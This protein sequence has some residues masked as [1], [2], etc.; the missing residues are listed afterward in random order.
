MSAADGE[1]SKLSRNG[2]SSEERPPRLVQRDV[3]D[4]IERTESYNTSSYVSGNAVVLRPNAGQSG[5]AGLWEK[6]I[7][8]PAINYAI[9]LFLT[10][11]LLLFALGAAFAIFLP[12]EPMLGDDLLRDV[13]PYFWGPGFFLLAPWQRWDTNW[14]LHIAQ[15]GYQA[16]DGTTNF[17]PLY[18]L[19]V[20]TVGRLLL[21]QYMLAALLVSAV[22]YLVAMVYLYRLTERFFNAQLAKRTLV[23]LVCFPTAFFLLS[24][25]TESLYLALAV[26]SFYYAEERRWWLVCGLSALAAITRLQGAILV[27]PLAYIYLKQERFKWRSLFKPDALALMG[28]PSAFILYMAYVYIVMR[29]TNFGNHLAIIWHIKFVMPWQ[30]LWDGLMVMFSLDNVQNLAYNLLDLSTLVLFICLTII[31]AQKKLPAAYWIYNAVNILVYLTREGETSLSWMSMSRYLIVLF[32]CFM[33]LAQ[34]APRWLLRLSIGLQAI[35]ATL[36]I[37]W[38][39]A[40]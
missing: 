26:A 6:L 15:I 1:P 37:F 13:N 14:Y 31:W 3:V 24:G 4:R 22:A 8:D 35:W 23:F 40:G 10:H 27:V 39:W 29:D 2:V 32:P 7:A 33:M 25:Y 21:G 12:I 30:S 17:P 18:P 34:S 11:R 9:N 16:G 19:L 36:F 20:G 5:L 28:A 38:M